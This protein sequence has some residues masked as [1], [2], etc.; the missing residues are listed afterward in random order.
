MKKQL[1]VVA[2]ASALASTLPTR[3][4]DF[5]VGANTNFSISGVVAVGIKDS[6]VYKINP[7]DQIPHHWSSGST[8][9]LPASSSP[10]PPTSSGPD[11]RRCST[12][13]AAFSPTPS[14]SIP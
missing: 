5:Q 13:R 4:A 12:S 11:G 1:I 14:P 2:A 9:T 10:A 8:T 7:N 6:C 3:A